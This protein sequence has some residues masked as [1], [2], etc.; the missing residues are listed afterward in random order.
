MGFP[1]KKLDRVYTY[2]DYLTWLDDERWELIDG[3]AWGMSPAP[4]RY[5][6]A[7]SRRLM[8]QIDACL[9]GKECF[10]YPAPFDVV[11][12]DSPNQEEKS[13]KTVVQP[14]ISV[15]CDRNKLTENGCTGAPDWIIEIL[16]PHTSRKDYLEKLYLYERHGVGEYWIVDPGNRFVHIYIL[17]ENG[18]YP[19]DP[20]LVLH[21][22]TAE[23]TTLNGLGINLTELFAV[24]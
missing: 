17:L 19:T 7:L 24:E 22:G 3:V 9:E 15:I 23:S 11:L 16:S 6:Q 8:S 10:S 18:S 14:D 1:V 2:G 21:D 20:I 4:S 13:A 12:P 5:H